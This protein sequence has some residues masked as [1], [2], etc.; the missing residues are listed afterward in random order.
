MKRKA[1]LCTV[2]TKRRDDGK[3]VVFLVDPRTG[4]K[5]PASG[6]LFPNEV[7]A[8]VRRVKAQLLKAGDRVSF[9]EA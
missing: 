5:C 9:T 3:S 6:P 4:R 7:E 8:T 1:P 2:V